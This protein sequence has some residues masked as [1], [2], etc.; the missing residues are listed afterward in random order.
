MSYK[1]IF[2]TSSLIML[3]SEINKSKVFKILIDL[4]YKPELPIS[5]YGEIKQQFEEVRRLL[6]DGNIAVLNQIHTEKFIKL[7]N[8]YPQLG[9]GELEVLSYGLYYQEIGDENYYCIL[10]DGLSRRIAE[11]IGIKFT[12]T[13]GL[14]NYL[15][16]NDCFS[17]DE[18][19]YIN[20]KLDYCR[21]PKKYR[22]PF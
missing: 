12:G 22:L 17:N 21:I 13:F 2:D 15:C 10:D 19:E 20:S 6:D 1:K 4:G 5:V 18:I 7:K 16:K 9:N 11:K 14:L 8:R 3:I